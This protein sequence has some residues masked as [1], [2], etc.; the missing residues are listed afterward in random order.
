[1]F[2]FS[3]VRVVKTSSLIIVDCSSLK[4]TFF[5]YGQ[6]AISWFLMFVLTSPLILLVTEHCF[7]FQSLLRHRRKDYI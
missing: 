1:M 7:V 4:Y 3:L 2:S 5:S 6:G